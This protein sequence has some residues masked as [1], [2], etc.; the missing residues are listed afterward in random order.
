MFAMMVNNDFPIIASGAMKLNIVL[1]PTAEAAFRAYYDF[2]ELK[3]KSINL[4]AISGLE[5]TTCLHFLDSIALLNAGSFENKRVIDIGSG[6]GFPGVPLKIVEPSINLTLLEATGKKVTFLKELCNKLGIEASFV[7]ARAEVASHESENREAYDIAISRAVARMNV[8]CEICLPFVSV[9]GLF[10]A[11]KSLDSEDE[12]EEAKSAIAAM[13]AQLRD[14]YEYE[15]PG[16]DRTHRAIIVRKTSNTPSKY[17]RRYA[18]I[19]RA[20]L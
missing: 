8:L 15:I 20:P 1:P 9:N 7:N 3:G 12:I 16:T 4:T 19:Q 17:P 5:E 14:N 11:M 13:G 18:K 6:A 10:I 2:L